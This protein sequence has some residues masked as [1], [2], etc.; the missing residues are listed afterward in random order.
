[1]ELQRGMRDKLDKYLAVCRLVMIHPY[2]SVSEVRLVT[3]EQLFGAVTALIQVQ[4]FF[5]RHL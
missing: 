1:M 5:R 2:T 4:G 3:A